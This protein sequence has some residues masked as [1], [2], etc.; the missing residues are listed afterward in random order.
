MFNIG[1]QQEPNQSISVTLDGNFFNIVIKQAFDAMYVTISINSVLTI[2]NVRAVT[3]TPIIPYEYLENGNFIF[4]T[5]NNELPFYTQF[6][7]TQSLVYLTA[8][9]VAELKAEVITYNDNINALSSF[10]F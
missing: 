3:G 8:E 10:S 2:S 6:G 1:L 5:L 9:E 7:I 4:L